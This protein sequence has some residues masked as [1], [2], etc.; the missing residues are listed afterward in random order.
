M[1][2][3]EVCGSLAIIW[4]ATHPQYPP[5]MVKGFYDYCRLAL[6]YGGPIWED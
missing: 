1:E 5:E 2:A 4:E 3:D 6:M